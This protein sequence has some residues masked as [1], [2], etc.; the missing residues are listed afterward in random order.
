[1]TKHRVPVADLVAFA[2]SLFVTKGVRPD[3]A[4]YVSQCLV[5]ADQE[6]V[7]SHGVMLVPMYL[8]R[9]EAGSVDARSQ[10]QVVSRK[11]GVAVVDAE[12]GLGQLTSRTAIALALDGAR[13]HGLGAVAVR[14][15]FHFGT[16]GHW[17][18]ELARAGCVG[19]V[20]SNTRPLMPG[21]GGA[22]P[23]VGNN[24]LAIAVPAP[25]EP[26]VLDMAL[27][28][29]AMGKIRIAAAAGRAIPGDWATDKNGVPTTDPAAAIEGM[30][31]PAAGPKGFGLAV[32]IDL[33][34][35]G[36]SSGGVGSAIK[37]LYGDPGQPYDC[38]HFFLA[39]QVDAFRSPAS[40]EGLVGEVIERIRTSRPVDPASPV[41][42]PGDPASNARRLAKKD[43]PV[44]PATLRSLEQAAQRANV[45]FPFSNPT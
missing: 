32:M 7:P 40:F 27:S 2:A 41:M 37:P 29:A 4:R 38:A 8:S 14:R 9:L 21:V 3:D 42:A 45:P 28:A 36:L 24:P 31:L 26:V 19:I 1:M 25:D 44:D 18:S 34:A 43:C 6:G 11:G 35:G 22:E 30:L 10:G 33:L 20:L 5:L 15:G 39:I 16:A 13:E 17:A 12:N 23:L